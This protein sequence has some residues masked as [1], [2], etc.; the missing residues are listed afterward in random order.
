MEAQPADHPRGDGIIRLIHADVTLA[1]PPAG[2]NS[3][4]F[5]SAA[6]QKL[7]QGAATDRGFVL[8]Q[9][10]DRWVPQLSSKRPGIVD[11]GFNWDN[12]LTWQEFTRLQQRY[13]AKAVG[14]VFQPERSAT[15]RC[16]LTTD[17][18]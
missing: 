5:E 13:A 3:S 14:Q 8:S 4:E 11:D 10:A 9:L 6:L 16:L 1:A 12:T 15:R 2:V 17:Q 7:H 18:R